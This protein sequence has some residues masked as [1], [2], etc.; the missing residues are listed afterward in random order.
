MLC[1]KWMARRRPIGCR[2]DAQVVCPGYQMTKTRWNVIDRPTKSDWGAP[3]LD[4]FI[5]AL[6]SSPLRD[7]I[8]LPWRRI[9]VHDKRHQVPS[10]RFISPLKVEW[11]R[12]TQEAPPRQCHGLVICARLAGFAASFCCHT[13]SGLWLPSKIIQMKEEEGGGGGVCWLIFRSVRVDPILL[14]L[15]WLKLF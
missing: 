15:N 2:I 8:W 6:S 9:S 1:L 5:S 10:S 4:G 13:D 3:K 14:N 11:M 12:R 7:S